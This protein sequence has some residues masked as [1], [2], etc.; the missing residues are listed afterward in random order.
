MHDV[1]V[2]GAG[3][4]G[5]YAAYKCASYGLDTLLVERGKLPRQKACGG[6][7]GPNTVSCLGKE[8]LDLVERSGSEN[9]IFFDLKLIRVLSKK[10]YYFRRGAFDHFITQLAESAGC[11]V[12]EGRNVRL[13]SVQKDRVEVKAA[14]ETYHS[15]IIIGGDGACSV[16]GNSVGLTHDLN[17]HYLA[18]RSQIDLPDSE[19]DT[20]LGIEGKTHNNTYFFS[21]LFGFGWLIPNRDS[22]NAGLGALI[23]RSSSLGERFKRFLKHFN[24]DHNAPAKG[25]IIPY[26]PLE[27]V[28]SERVCL[29]GDAGGFVN[30]WNGCGIDLGIESSERV[31]EICKKAIEEDD[32]SESSLSRYPKALE[33]QMKKLQFRSNVL[34][35]LDDLYPK[36][37]P[38]TP[39]G[40]PFVRSLSKLA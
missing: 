5:S 9:H 11:R 1:I 21:D 16:V 37:L 8:V 25:H 17:R 39:L 30:P 40:E 28:Y 14:G 19:I 18:L 6:A 29:V 12:E 20:L 22:I 3:P 31:A 23:R 33:S 15:K 24:L 4:A 35:L 36:A 38:L 10:K 34:G 27:K 26:H 32:F 13:V 2:V 7:V